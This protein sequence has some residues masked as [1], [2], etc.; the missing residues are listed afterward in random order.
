MTTTWA[1][2]HIVLGVLAA[3]REI[4]EA[5]ARAGVTEDLFRA[6]LSMSPGRAPQEPFR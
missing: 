4:A 6:Q 5:L 1:P 2:E 3:D